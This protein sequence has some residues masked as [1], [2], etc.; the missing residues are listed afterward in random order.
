MSKPHPDDIAVDRFA[1]AMK[2]KLAEKRNEGFSGWCDPTQCPIDYL[3]A[4]LAEQIHSR[5]VL[6]P[7]DIGNFAMM[8]FNRPGEVPDRGR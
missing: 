8:I 3:T 7:V 2:E 1:A 4:K 6:D 5:P